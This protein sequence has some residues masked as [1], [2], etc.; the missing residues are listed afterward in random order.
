MWQSKWV[1]PFTAL[2]LRRRRNL[3]LSI[4]SSLGL[5]L[6]AKIPASHP[7]Y[8]LQHPISLCCVASAAMNSRC[9]LAPLQSRHG[10]GLKVVWKHHP[11]ADPM[12]VPQTGARDFCRGF[13][14]V[15]TAGRSAVMHICGRPRRGIRLLYVHVLLI[16]HVLSK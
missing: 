4:N 5:V 16:E 10:C 7:V 14:F 9:V 13:A 8:P 11:P 15:R 3:S 1:I 6:R 12:K 2:Q